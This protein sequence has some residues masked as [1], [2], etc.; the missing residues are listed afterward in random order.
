MATATLR[1]GRPEARSLLEALGEIWVR[2]ASVDWSR[3]FAGTGAR[4]V[5]LP[6]YAFQRERFWWEPPAREASGEERLAYRIDWQPLADPPRAA[7]RDIWLVV[8]AAQRFDG[9]SG[10]QAPDGGVEAAADLVRGLAAQL[11]RHGAQVRTVEVD[12][13]TV[14]RG[15]LTA[16]LRDALDDRPVGGVLSLL[17]VAQGVHPE[18]PA[19]PLGLTGTLVL[20]Q[21]LGDAGVRAPLWSVTR[22]AVAAVPSDALPSPEQAT[23]WG[24]GRVLGL[25]DPARW[26]GLIDLQPEPDERA[27]ERLCAVLAAAGGEDQ[28]AL[29]SEGALARRLVRTSLGA[30]Q[31]GGEAW[32]APRGTV[33]LTGG[34]GALGGH[35]A[36]WL[37]QRGAE[38]ILLASRRGADAP[39]VAELE[40]DLVDLGAQV[41]VAA[42]DVADR[43]QLEH[44]LDAIPAECP[45]TAVFHAAGEL[46]QE[47]IDALTPGQLERALA[48]KAQAALHLHELTAQR[49]LSS[50]VL[51]S[52]IAGTLGSGGQAG[53]AAANA[54]LDALA[55][56]RRARGLPATSIAWG[57]WAGAGMAAEKGE[58]L[59]LQGVRALP[60]ATALDALE[61]I[62]ARDDGA[63]ARTGLA[64]DDQAT[65]STPV[66][67]R[68]DQ[69]TA[70]TPVPARDDQ[71][72][73]STPVPARE[74]RAAACTVIADLDW[75][76]YAPLFAAARPRPLIA[77]CPRYAGPEPPGEEGS[78]GSEAAGNGTG[79]KGTARRAPR[80]RLA[81]E[82]AEMGASEREAAVLELVRTHTAAVLG[83][84]SAE[85]VPARRPF[86]ELG[87]DS[88]AGVQLC[89]RLGGGNRA[90]AAL[91]AYLRP[92]HPAGACRAPAGR[93]DRRPPRNAHGDC[94]G[95][96]R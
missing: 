78:A 21:A 62:L 32:R 64:R 63:A 44:L 66:P 34:S 79:S 3:P 45:L 82:L 80:G 8:Q 53:Y 20:A 48:A 85:P 35:L 5:A 30:A 77:D 17:P 73:A 60:A 76:R 57:A 18:W 58:R 65:A 39:G 89:E 37:A 10:A 13:R 83:H 81:G 24:L 25:E 59:R 74:H 84:S 51:C 93:A 88:L 2:G 4:R 75:E 56:H 23:V 46:E 26:G 36:R 54:Y 41:T 15:A 12:P 95:E 9:E 68:D 38:H 52:S 31:A 47:S 43:A 11:E 42:C 40:R 16:G 29:R 28:L 55:E 72:T 87:F 27:L 7:L 94:G 61:R 91:D 96:S 69:A 1:K 70:S 71:A 33:L 90:A 86:K 92:P 67:A 22:G 49:D 14:E 50:F 6:T 19:V